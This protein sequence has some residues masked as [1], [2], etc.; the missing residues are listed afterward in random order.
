M[1]SCL[2]CIYRAI[3]GARFDFLSLSYPSS[4][5]L[6]CENILELLEDLGNKTTFERGVRGLENSKQ[7]FSLKNK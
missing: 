2:I 7:L 5:N 1:V 4:F 6:F 3:D